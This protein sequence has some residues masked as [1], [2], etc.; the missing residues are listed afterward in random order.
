[1]FDFINF[2]PPENFYEALFIFVPFITLLVGLA[3]LIL[4]K[5]MLAVC[6]LQAK[7]NAPEAIGEGRASWAGIMLAMALGCL[8]LQEPKALQPGLSL[9]LGLAWLI[10]A[11]GFC[12][13]GLLNGGFNR[14][15]LLRLV[16]SIFFACL[17]LWFSESL[18]PD[19]SWPTRFQDWILFLIAFLT[20]ILGL[21]SGFLPA[22]ALKI[23]RLQPKD[24]IK[25][26]QGESRNLLAGFNISLGSSYL[27]FPQAFVFIGL[28][29]S[30]AWFL[31]GIGRLVSIV[32]DRGFTVYNVAGLLFEL[33]VGIVGFSV[34]FGII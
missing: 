13:Q 34:I 3:F 2:I 26:A 33:S 14:N 17:G 8:V 31:T 23:L 12:L 10:S 24:N 7:P 20:L 18:E 19:F 32:F 11:L 30:L 5:Q 1:M 25:T 21:I 15:L 16:A 4:P 6:G 22:F 29:L 27:I 28:V 9:M